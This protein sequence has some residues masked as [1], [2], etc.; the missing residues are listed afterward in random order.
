MNHCFVDNFCV[1]SVSSHCDQRCGQRNHIPSDIPIYDGH[2]HLNQMTSKIQSDLLSIKVTPPIRQFYFINNN[3]KPDEWL[4][5][6]PSLNSS[7]VHIRSTI[8]IHPKYFTPKSLYQTL[9]NLR[10]YLEISHHNQSPENKIVAVGEC[11]LDETSTTS[12]KHQIFVFE[13]QID[14]AMQFD[15]P[16]VLHCRG[17]HLY[18]K[19]FDCLK[20]RISDKNQR[21]HWHCINSNANL[22]IVDLFLNQFPNSYIGLNGSITYET[23]FENTLMFKNWLIDRSRYLPDRLIFETDYPYLSPRNLH[24]TYDPSCALLATSEYLSKTIDDTNQNALS[25]LQF[26]NRNIETMYAL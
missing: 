14:L 20:S 1:A 18:K 13:K 2:I 11:G 10:T 16:I 17:S 21:L 3:H 5:P 12:I 15:L 22:Y 24:G 9:D 26:S 7:H 19:L 8:G 6:N 23:N 4:I 25:Y